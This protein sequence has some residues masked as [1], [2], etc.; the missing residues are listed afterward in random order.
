MSRRAPRPLT[1]TRV[2][3]RNVD[4][5]SRPL[6]ACRTCGS[7]AGAGLDGRCAWC[8]RRLTDEWTPVGALEAAAQPALGPADET[9]TP[10]TSATESDSAGARAR[11]DTKKAGKK[12]A[13]DERKAGKKAAKDERKA[14]KKAAKRAVKGER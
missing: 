8:G 7:T 6:G 4:P 12:A 1:K 11:K 5:M 9:T 13:K 14:G 10:A 3:W 2:G